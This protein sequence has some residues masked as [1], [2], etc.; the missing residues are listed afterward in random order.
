MGGVRERCETEREREREREREKKVL[1]AGKVLSLP[2][3]HQTVLLERILAR[4]V[5]S[6]LQDVAVQLEPGALNK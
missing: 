4:N 1:L 3:P 5:I 2:T 6:H